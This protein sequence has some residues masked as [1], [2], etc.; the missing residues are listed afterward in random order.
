M[1]LFSIYKERLSN[2]AAASAPTFIFTGV[3]GD[4]N[5]RLMTITT[6]ER[7]NDIQHRFLAYR[8]GELDHVESVFSDLEKVLTPF[9]RKR[10][11]A[12][13]DVSDVCQN[14]LLKIHT[15]RELFDARQSLK[16]WVYV[17][18]R[19]V[20]VD[21]FRKQQK[22]F[23]IDDLVAHFE[24]TREL[25]TEFEDLDEMRELDI[26]L[27]KLKPVDRD[28]LLMQSREGKSLRE[29]ADTLGMNEGAVK[30]RAHRAIKQLRSLL[31]LLIWF[32]LGGRK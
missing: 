26:A 5:K 9:F 11:F 25:N 30:V 29:I 7:W 13:D 2:S 19:S 14:T 8:E 18:A 21:H 16:S 31:P 10:L 27:N 12:K 4:A 23:S 15:S 32:L 3:G 20:L 28:I 1:C 24:Q 17:I 22:K 6:P